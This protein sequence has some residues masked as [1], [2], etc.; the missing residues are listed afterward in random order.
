MKK[1][2]VALAAI[3]VLL[4][5]GLAI[6]SALI[7]SNDALSSNESQ[8][9]NIISTSSQVTVL[10]A[11]LPPPPPDG[12]TSP[13]E[14]YPT[15]T[16]TPTPAPLE[17][18]P[19]TPPKPS[20]GET[21]SGEDISGLPASSGMTSIAEGEVTEIGGAPAKMK[22]I[23][24]SQLWVLYNGA[25]TTGNAAL[26]AGD[27]TSLLLYN[28]QGQGIST[29]ET[30]PNGWVE[31][32]NW[33]YLNPEYHYFTYYDDAVGWHKI[34]AKGSVT[35][36]SN[37][38][39]IYV[40]PTGPTPPTPTPTPFTVSA[41]WPSSTYYTIGSS[42]CIYFT[43]NKPCYARVTYI[44]ENSNIV[45]SGP[46]YVSAGTHTD[47]GTIGHPKGMRVVVVDAWTSSGEH[48]S[49]VTSYNVG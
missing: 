18:Q 22:V 27:R 32:I 10:D 33:G 19:S 38:I 31:K 1:N 46:S 9:S 11:P 28:D 12:E 13:A 34:V 37:V 48:D 4:F 30:Y 6:C 2:I 39:W 49:A 40:W 41:A 44:K 25:W 29:E 15:G 5:S 45:W 35:G 42:T 21:A 7:P 16:L 17:G 20:T 14:P 23:S 3:V 43:V 24:G 47:T 26:Y 8:Q 36:Q